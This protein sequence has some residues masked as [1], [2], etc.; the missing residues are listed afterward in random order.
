[1]ENNKER[2]RFVAYVLTA[3]LIVSFIIATTSLAFSAQPQVAAGGVHTVGLKTDGTVVA[4]GNSGYGQCEVS[5]W[6]DIDQVAA[7]YYHTVGL[8]TDGTVVAVGYNGYSQC[9]LFDWN[10][11]TEVDSDGDG[12]PDSLDACPTEDATGFDADGD[13]CIDSADDLGSLVES[14]LEEGVIEEEMENSLLSKIE[15]AENSADKDNICTAINQ[16]EALKKSI[17][18]QRGKKIYNE[19]ADQIIAYVN[20]LIAWY[21]DQL[22][23]GES[24]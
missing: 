21:L 14:L 17:D 15:N 13:G 11:A 4:V 2:K 3:F 6:T 24:C 1:M 18:A 5:S 20:S 9:N 16:L 10:L 22:P 23:E 19:A 12:I 8:K 7:G